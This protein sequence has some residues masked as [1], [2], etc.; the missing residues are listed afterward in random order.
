MAANY[1]LPIKVAAQPDAT[2]C[3]PTCL[4]AMYRFFDDPIPLSQVVSEVTSLPTGGTLAV[5]L[6]CHALRR[7]YSSTIYTYNLRLFDPTWFPA[8]PRALTERLEVQRRVKNDTKLDLASQA[9][10]EFLSLGGS[11]QYEDLTPALIERHLRQGTPFM[12]GLSATYLYGCARER[13][14]GYDDVGGD[15]V[16][17]FVVVNGYDSEQGQVMV[18]DPLHDNPRFDTPTYRVSVG[19]LI[20]AI[21]LG[22]VTYDANLLMIAPSWDRGAS[23]C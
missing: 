10:V 12:T 23:P 16:G 18:A 3:G 7:G 17:H 9:Y 8:T 15:P 11:V 1:F 2:T 13:D 22:I 20:G 6:G 5:W 19:R 21:L 14:D 4:H